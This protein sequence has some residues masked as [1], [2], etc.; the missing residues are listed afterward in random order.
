MNAL[1][2]YGKILRHYRLDN[3]I[4]LADMAKTLGISP[5]YLS[6]IET[7]SKAVPVDL[8]KK[9]VDMYGFDEEM[10]T[11]LIK[12]EA[13]TNKSLTIDLRE[14]SPEAVDATVIFAREIRN[15]SVHEVRDLYE[16]MHKRKKETE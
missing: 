14:A 8:T 12:A 9:V 2:E 13:E 7:G 16:K 1:T 15:L 3:Q 5:A 4:L 10:R 11:R 6:S